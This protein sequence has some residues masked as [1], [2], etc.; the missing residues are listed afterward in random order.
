MI[1]TDKT[2][3]KNGSLAQINND[4]KLWQLLFAPER[5]GPHELI[6]Y[7][8]RTNDRESSKSDA[9][10]NL[11]VTKLRRS[12]KFHMIYTQFQTK[13]CQ[14]YTPMDGILKK[15]SVVHIHCVISGAKDVNLT[16]D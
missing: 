10:F 8:K 6:V 13:K 15:D 3:Y 16:I 9:K 12:M 11:N 7:A 14:I 1:N 5:T 2:I 4:K